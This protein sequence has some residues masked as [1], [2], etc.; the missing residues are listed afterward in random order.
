MNKEKDEEKTQK[1]GIVFGKFYP[2]HK[3]HVDFIQK[4]SG[5]VDNLYVVVCTENERDIKLFEESKM[6]KMPTIKDRIRFVGQTFREQKNIRILHL[7]E[8]GIPEYPNGWKGWSDRVRDLLIKNNIRIDVIFTNETQDVQNYK[9]NFVNK[10]SAKDTFNDSLEIKTIDVSRSNFHI[11]AT[12]IRK[13]P[14]GNWFFIPRY[15]REFFILKVAIIGSENSGKT[16]LTQKLA[17]YYNTTYVKEYRKKYIEEV[18]QNNINNLQYEDYSQ[19]AYGHNAEIL[20]SIKS[21]DKL[22]FIDT[23]FTSLQ[24][25]S[26]LNTGKKHPIINDFIKNSNFDIII[27]IENTDNN[28]KNK[29]KF[30][31][32]LK[33]L[34]KS[35]NK[36][37][38]KLEHSVEKNKYKFTENYNKAIDIINNYI[39]NSEMK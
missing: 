30:D 27:Y 37:Y 3:G 34:L 9:E 36:E 29:K 13:N 35:H 8:D 33:K 24:A 23:D 15:I 2:L 31:K 19:I 5:F 6:K 18:L 20:N 7:V 25:F 1:N 12:E 21:A 38:F 11:S 14:Y 28:A 16:N 17:N 22:L 4:A 39:E 32:E 10:N 26:I